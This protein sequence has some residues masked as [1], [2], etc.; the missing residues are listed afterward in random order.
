M[1]GTRRGRV[2]ATLID[3][4]GAARTPGSSSESPVGLGWVVMRPG[5]NGVPVKPSDRSPFY[6]LGLSPL[7]VATDTADVNTRVACVSVAILTLAWANSS[8]AQEHVGIRAGVS[9]N[10]DQFVLGGHI[11]TSPLLDRLVFRP[12]AE[13]GI[14][15]DLVLIAFNLEF[16]YKIPLE[17]NPWTVYVGAG[18]ALN[19]LSFSNDGRRG[20]NDTEAEGG[21]NILVGAEHSEGLFTEFKIGVSDSPDLKFLVGYSF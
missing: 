5:G 4:D 19:I 1:D 15:S 17:D 2:L 14:G 11:E 6:P 18:P 8:A 13:V 7:D 12:N 21:F 20:R 16:A 3:D 9:G 10:P